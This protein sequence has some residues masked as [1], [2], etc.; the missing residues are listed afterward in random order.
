MTR[1]GQV[2][3]HIS[4]TDRARGA[5]IAAAYGDAAGWP[6]EKPR[7]RV[8]RET[9][10]PKLQSALLKSW[11]RRAGGR[12]FSHEE[13]I[14]AGEYSDDTQ[15]LLCTARSVLRDRGGWSW[16]T[17]RE[18][19]TWLLYERGGGLSTKQAAE[20]WAQGLP[21][22]ST[23]KKN[24]KRK[25]Y[26]EA[27]GN[28][29]AMRILPHC[30]KNG[31][32]N[33]FALIAENILAN[34]LCTHGHPRALVGALAYGYAVWESV[35]LD[36]PMEYGYLIERLLSGVDE[37][38]GL[39]VAFGAGNQWLQSAL[40][41][42]DGTYRDLWGR[43]V[44]E[45]VDLLE[46]CQAAMKKGALSVDEAV[47]KELGCFDRSTGGAGTISAAAAVFLASRFAA[48][49]MNGV[50]VAA[51]AQGTDTDTLASM[52]G[53]LLGA[54]QGGEWLFDVRDAV[55]DSSYIVELAENVAR[56]DVSG[57]WTSEADL[58]PPNG[59]D[60][61]SFAIRLESVK[62]GDTVVLPDERKAKVSDAKTLKEGSNVTI[63][64]WRLVTSDGQTVFVKRVSR[65]SRRTSEARLFDEADAKPSEVFQP[66]GVVKAG[67]RLAVA[68]LR[69]A[70]EF[71]EKVL[72]LTVIRASGSLVNLGE[73]I[74]L[75]QRAPQVVLDTPKESSR[76]ERIVVY[77]QTKSLDVVY[78]NVLRFG[79]QIVRQITP[80][81]G[82]RFFWCRDP[83]GNTVE[84]SEYEKGNGSPLQ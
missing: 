61:E 23:E 13:T 51:L 45:Q 31:P 12:F 78:K 26:F 21:P 24:E 63:I 40:E 44:D 15:L 5:F 55:Q 49:P 7:F 41:F 83:D 14:N 60:L 46:K 70:R 72:G 2:S 47:L 4:A 56:K 39:S 34:G 52:T 64:R 62:P 42:S 50:K 27:G 80:G 32:G 84:V 77:I 75:S 48:D 22:W 58:A 36:P 17:R 81:Q 37:W 54:I 65:R 43:T 11:V 67:M 68:D 6:E 74:A 69:K 28:G 35:R 53:A 3:S 82:R 25:R 19:P 66:A 71:Y 79:A 33:G 1:K 59:A 38:S 73:V 30:F 18:L 57:E 29:A 9:S 10:E 8:N 76:E 20:C 16:F